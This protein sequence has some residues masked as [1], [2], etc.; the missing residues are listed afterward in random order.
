VYDFVIV[1]SGPSGSVIAH[2]LAASGA[3]CV[4]LEAGK[5]FTAETFP[6]D[7]LGYNVGLFWNGGVEL[8]QDA[9][10]VFLRGKCVGGTSIVN[11]ALLDRFD[12]IAW[13]DWQ[14]DTGFPFFTLEG[15]APHFEAVEPHLSIQEMPERLR[16]RNAKL[17]VEGH[18]KLGFGWAPMERGQTNCNT[19]GGNDC[20]ACLGGCRLD[21]KQSMLV[22]F[23][24][25][26]LAAG[27]ELRPEFTVETVEAQGGRVIVRGTGREGKAE[28][29]GRRLV[30]AAGVMGNVQILLRSGFGSKLP[31]LGRRLA[32]HPQSMHFGLFDEP[33]DGHKGAFQS[34]KSKDLG[35]R[36]RGFKLENVFT[37]P[38][39]IAMVLPGWGRDHQRLMKRY[40]HLAC[41]EVAVRDESAG[42]VR[43]SRNGRLLVDKPL[44]AQDE[45]RARDGLA[46]VDEV[47]RAAGA[48]EIVHSKI[49]FSVHLMGGCA[50]GADAAT[51]VVN[52]GFALHTSPDIF[53]ADSSAFPNAP[54]INP[55]LAIMAVSHRAAERMLKEAS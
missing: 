39:A 14:A 29:S 18:K 2:K 17:F 54:G 9:S 26:A 51:S 38:I 44:T 23:L 46:T 21:S 22:T 7:E 32:C 36:Q 40:R 28:V 25:K 30:L 43:L 24:P 12:D 10:L 15:M 55:S 33:V 3:R 11:Q 41:M 16:N 19:E 6:P 35:L 37:P 48:I 8:T 49:W 27:L 45:S 50:L 52:E 20:L 13:A 1:G 53:I 31:A 47:F 4:M 34:V 5:H 42:T